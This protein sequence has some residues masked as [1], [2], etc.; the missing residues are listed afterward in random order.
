MRKEF[1]ILDDFIRQKAL[2]RTPQRE[3]VL[4]VF[5]RVEGHVSL[6]ELSR[7]VKK[8]YPKIGYTTVYRTMRLLAETGLCNE[9]DFGHGVLRYEHKYNHSHHDHLVCKKCG[10]YIEVFDPQIEK[11]QDKLAAKC[12]FKPDSHRLQIFGVC[13]KCQARYNKKSK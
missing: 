9:V 4:D 10:R 13:S 5:I 3:N 6:D 2:R 11:M 12:G 8:K 7:F 1:Q